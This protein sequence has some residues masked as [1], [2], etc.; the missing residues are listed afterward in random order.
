MRE[1]DDLLWLRVAGLGMRPRLTGFLLKLFYPEA[2]EWLPQRL[3]CVFPSAVMTRQMV[4]GVLWR[5]GFN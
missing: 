1:R 2:A 3:M 5:L 4:G